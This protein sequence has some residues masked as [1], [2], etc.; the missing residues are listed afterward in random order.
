MTNGD[1]VFANGDQSLTDAK[2]CV[3]QKV[4]IV[5]A[6]GNWVLAKSSQGL[7]NFSCLC[8]NSTITNLTIVKKVV[9]GNWCKLMNSVLIDNCQW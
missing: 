7:A 5:L 9:D 2:W 1:W 6:N 8:T 4:Y 3:Y